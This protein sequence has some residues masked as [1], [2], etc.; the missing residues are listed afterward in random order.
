MG[1]AGGGGGGEGKV[2]GGSELAALLSFGLWLVYCL[3]D[4]SLGVIGRLCSL[5]MPFPGHFSCYFCV[6]N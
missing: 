6:F 2:C 4:L 5:I 3:I 1:A